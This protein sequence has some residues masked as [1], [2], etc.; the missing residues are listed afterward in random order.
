MERELDF[1]GIAIP[2]LVIKQCDLVAAMLNKIPGARFRIVLPDG[3]L[4]QKDMEEAP[5][6]SG[7]RRKRAHSPGELMPHYRSAVEAMNV[8][9][10]VTLSTPDGCEIETLRGCACSLAVRLW[11]K[12]AHVSMI[13]REK[14]TI[15][16]MRTGGK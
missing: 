10:V 16:V 4:F 2:Q 13:N 3:S 6:Q 1:A 11:G 15:E 5:P 14:N 12:G 7:V 8:G 9:D